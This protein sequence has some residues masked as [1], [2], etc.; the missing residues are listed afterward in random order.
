MGACSE[1]GYYLKAGN[2]SNFYY[3]YI[4]AYIYIY[5]YHTGGIHISADS[6]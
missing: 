1:V 2:H 5:V 4:T 3:I 6:N